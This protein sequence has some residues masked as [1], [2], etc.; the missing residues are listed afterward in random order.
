[1]KILEKLS[2]KLNL[3]LTELKIFLF[4]FFSLII[5][6]FINLWKSNQNSKYLDFDYSEQDSMFYSSMDNV[7][8]EDSIESKNQIDSINN[9]SFNIKENKIEKTTSNKKEKTNKIIKINSAT[10]EEISSLPGIGVKTA[11]NIIE[12]RNK[13]G[14]IDKAEELL[15]IKGIGKSKLE[16]IRMLLNFDK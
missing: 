10:E 14:S 4:L 9:N 16:K 2:L 7:E 6:F 11:S 15:N 3:T 1:M 13:K 5:G 8:Y 12:Y